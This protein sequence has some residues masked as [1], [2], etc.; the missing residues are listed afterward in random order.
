MSFGWMLTSF[1]SRVSSGGDDGE[2]ET[3][4]GRGMEPRAF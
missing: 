2:G 1:S 4:F 3:K